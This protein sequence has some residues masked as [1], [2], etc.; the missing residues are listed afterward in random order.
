MQGKR[1][2]QNEVKECVNNLNISNEMKIDEGK[3]KL[4]E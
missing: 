2:G 3:K 4:E 1:W